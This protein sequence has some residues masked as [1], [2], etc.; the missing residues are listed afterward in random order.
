MAELRD[1]LSEALRKKEEDINTYIWKFPRDAEKPRQQVKLMDC[2]QEQLQQFYNHCE[3]MLRNTNKLCLGRYNLLV[4]IKSQKD[5]IGAELLLREMQEENKH[6]TRFALNEAIEELIDNNK[7]KGVIIDTE[8]STFE[9]YTS[10]PLSTKYNKLSL[11]LIRDACTNRLGVFDNSHITKSFLL[12]R[13]L[14][15][16][17]EDIKKLNEYAVKNKLDDDFKKLDI[18]KKYLNLRDYHIL[19]RNSRG[20]SLQELEQMLLLHPCKFTDLNTEQLEILRYK[21]LPDL[22]RNVKDH[23]ERWETLS[24]QIK[25]VAKVKKYTLSVKKD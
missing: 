17:K 12:K 23:I 10:T 9:Q 6:F 7:K 11:Q 16:S 3:S 4:L 22:E 24:S 14:W 2:T 5:K 13:G 18:V 19:K 25:K 21:I 20:L 8:I 15:L 1:K